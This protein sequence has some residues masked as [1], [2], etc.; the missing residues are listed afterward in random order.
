MTDGAVTTDGD[1]GTRVTVTVDPQTDKI[2]SIYLG[3][4]GGLPDGVQH[5]HALLQECRR[6]GIDLGVQT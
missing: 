4:R 2:E 5:G 6:R 3:G 1:L